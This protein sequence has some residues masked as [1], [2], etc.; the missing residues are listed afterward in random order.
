M[1]IRVVKELV[2][3][4]KQSKKIDATIQALASSIN[5]FNK[6]VNTLGSLQDGWLGG[7]NYVNVQGTFQ[8]DGSEPNNTI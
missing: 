8:P 1:V 3:Q 4:S 7:G 2:L 5:A 6:T